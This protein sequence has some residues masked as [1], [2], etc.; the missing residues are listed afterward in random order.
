MSTRTPCAG[1]HDLFDSTDP[2]VHALAA[3]LCAGCP[4]IDAC[5]QRLADVIAT[6][7][8]F[9]RPEGTWAGELIVDHNARN[10]RRRER[11]GGGPAKVTRTERLREEEERYSDAEAHSARC[12]ALRGD[13]SEW[14][15]TGRRVY[16]RRAKRRQPGRLGVAS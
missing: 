14:A 9:G 8:Y 16:D 4:L 13:T 7:G 1:R 15:L 3:Q 10:Q 2:E 12:A 5:R 6:G 11:R